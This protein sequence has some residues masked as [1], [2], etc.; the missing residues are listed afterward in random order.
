M[1]SIKEKFLNLN[2]EVCHYEIVSRKGYGYEVDDPIRL[3]SVFGEYS[4]IN[5]LAPENKSETAF[6]LKEI[7]RLETTFS[8]KL[9]STIVHLELLFLELENEIRVY[10]IYDLYFCAYK[11]NNQTYSK[12]EQILC[13]MGEFLN[14]VKLPEGFRFKVRP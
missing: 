2:K 7:N 14:D 11:E 12:V 13:S 6:C 3:K 8:E 4:L 9:N 5:V 1:Q 10:K